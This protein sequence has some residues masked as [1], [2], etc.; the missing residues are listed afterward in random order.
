MSDRIKISQLPVVTRATSNDY[1]V[2]NDENLISSQI[3]WRNVIETISR[4]NLSFTGSVNLMGNTFLTGELS[5][6][7]FNLTKWPGIAITGDSITNWN[8][9]Y[10]WGNHADGGYM[11]DTYVPEQ[12]DFA[13]T[14]TTLPTY[15]KNKPNIIIDGEGNVDNISFDLSYVG[16][17][18]F[19]TL[20]NP[21]G[22]DARI[23]A[24]TDLAAGLMTPF[25][26][27]Q[28]QQLIDEG[29]PPQSDWDER[30][31]G[32][33]SEIL[34]QPLFVFDTD[35]SVYESGR[36][37]NVVI[38]L[39]YTPSNKAGTLTAQDGS[40]VKIDIVRDDLNQA[41]LMLPEDKALVNQLPTDGSGNL[42]WS[43][44]QIDWDQL[45]SIPITIDG[46]G[47]VTNVR[48]N[49]AYFKSPVAGLITNSK[50]DN[51]IITLADN[52][53]AGLMKPG[54]YDKLE[55]IEEDA[56]KNF[57]LTQEYNHQLISGDIVTTY[58]ADTFTST[59]QLAGYA[60]VDPGA[61]GS[62]I[63]NFNAG[64]VTSTERANL[65]R[66]SDNF[67]DV[68]GDLT[69]GSI[70]VDYNDLDNLPVIPQLI[71]DLTDVN[72]VPN[73]GDFLTW[74]DTS[75]AWIASNIGD[76]FMF[77]GVVDVTVA[78]P[79][80]LPSN[81]TVYIVEKDGD[82]VW[83]GIATT[84]VSAGDRV[85][86]DP[87]GDSGNGY[88]YHY[89][90][91]GASPTPN[92]GVT[93][94]VTTADVTNTAGT[95]ATLELAGTQN[96][97]GSANNNAGLVTATERAKLSTIE[98]NAQVNVNPS[99]V[100]HNS[101][102]S[103]K[104]NTLELTPGGDLTA[105]P[106]ATDSIDGLTSAAD[107]AKLDLVDV[108]AEP[109][110]DPTATFVVGTDDGTLT[111]LPGSDTTTIPGATESAAGLMSKDD[112]AKLNLVEDGAEA[113]INPTATFAAGTT[114]GTLTLLPGSDTTTIPGATLSSAGLMS[115][116]DK[117][118]L[119]DLI[120]NPP[121]T[122]VDLDSNYGTSNH[123]ILTDDGAGNQLGKPTAIPLA[124]TLNVADP[125]DSGA[126][127]DNAGLVTHYERGLINQLPTDASGDL[128]LKT[129][130][131]PLSEV[132][133][134]GNVAGPGQSIRF[135]TSPTPIGLP[136]N[137]AAMDEVVGVIQAGFG[138]YAGNL[139]KISYITPEVEIIGD[140][141]GDYWLGDEF[142]NGV[143]KFETAI[144]TQI[145]TENPN[146]K[147]GEPSY[148]AG[149]QGIS[150]NPSKTSTSGHQGRSFSV[151][152][153]NLH[154]ESKAHDLLLESTSWEGYAKFKMEGKE[155]KIDTT[156][157]T[158]EAKEFIGDGTKLTGVLPYDFTTLDD[159][160]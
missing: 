57:S 67:I 113:N 73:D 117:S 129:G 93:Y 3:S 51:A 33:A 74:S 111:L 59:I 120:S 134:E 153:Y 4:T 2:I 54:H 155:A 48:V 139:V 62:D 27:D 72:A 9:A 144:E 7:Q 130:A 89:P 11:P 138:N 118:D 21:K 46:D 150:W 18:N 157:G 66:L 35:T 159:L 101:L 24:V 77:G 92:L 100:W 68:G 122:T 128:D 145:W 70:T 53:S 141:G 121:A 5:F 97:G 156:T 36:V 115:S 133:D 1:L 61:D 106:L 96:A 147:G 124:G 82:A 80:P 140:G 109:N 8:E 37:K 137:I 40:N 126:D 102:D 78:Q 43:T 64:L 31:S 14:D 119:Q 132:L 136:K 85:L 17:T 15:I 38:D 65:I 60:L 39:E 131:S 13:E 10:G 6:S 108:S 58:G 44:I 84:A 91:L 116:Q 103:V 34:N 49:L 104:P 75:S 88:N 149:A 52:V 23:T 90:G 151:T 19:G 83:T 71:N 81:P 45:T 29:D 42:D 63:S 55:N 56:E 87:S 148:I 20:I 76:V 28:L 41:G 154:L 22:G 142:V 127:K 107:K 47:N 135:S 95:D 94:D 50:G 16:S 32:T 158:I 152:P 99:S 98:E 114:D 125:S 25:Q 30:G 12:S 86:W 123:T 160:P 110:I 26:K 143:Y 112:K 146:A 79:T 69:L 105:I